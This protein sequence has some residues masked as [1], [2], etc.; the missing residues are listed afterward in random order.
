MNKFFIISFFIV[1]SFFLAKDVFA[2]D[3]PVFSLIVS[4]NSSGYI[5]SGDSIGCSSL[6]SIYKVEKRGEDIYVCPGGSIG[7]CFLLNTLYKTSKYN[8]DTTYICPS[9]SFGGC[10]VF[11]VLYKISKHDENTSYVCPGDSIGGCSIFNVLYKVS[12]YNT[13]TTFV[14]SGNS[15]GNCSIFNV[16]YKFKKTDTQLSGYSGINYSDQIKAERDKLA[17][18]EQEKQKLTENYLNALSNLNTPQ[19]T[20]PVNSTLNGTVCSCNDGYVS[21][22]TACITYA[23]NCQSKY[24]ANSYG[25]KQFCHCFAGYKWNTSQ[26]ACIKVETKP[27]TQEINDPREETPKIA[28]SEEKLDIK[29]EPARENTSTSSG[30]EKDNTPKE[31]VGKNSKQG[32]FIRMSWSIKNFFLKIFR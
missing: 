19:Y 29:T 31:E 8:Q 10:S 6:S 24:G 9:N 27:A 11:N 26:T 21:N 13:D 2:M 22:G 17:Q 23:Q 16:L 18:L 12:K 7:G 5:C 1:V 3:I 25:D 4:E 14:C 15:I 28:K 32:F 30:P 20:C